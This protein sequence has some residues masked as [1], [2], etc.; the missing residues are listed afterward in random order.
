MAQAQLAVSVSPPKVVGQKA[1]V[2]LALQ[3]SFAENVTSARA[4]CFLLDEHGKMVG[5]ATRWVIGGEAS[6]PGLAAGATNAFHFVIASPVPSG[7]TTTNLTSKV[8]FSRVV[9]EGGKLANPSKT[10]RIQ[11]ATK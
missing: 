8:S 7:F 9:L 1:V 4:V 6:Q 5:Q 10:V 2:S 3:N 11:D